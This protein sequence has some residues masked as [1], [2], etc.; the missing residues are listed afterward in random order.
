MFERHDAWQSVAFLVETFCVLFLGLGFTVILLFEQSHNTPLNFFTSM[1][2]FQY[3]GM[4]NCH[5]AQ[6]RHEFLSYCVST[7]YIR[8]TEKIKLTQAF[9]LISRVSP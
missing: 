3:R 6:E 7:S 8:K 5:M 4:I 9:F 2:S 1:L